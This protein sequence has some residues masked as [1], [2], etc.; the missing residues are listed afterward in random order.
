MEME[1]IIHA[2]LKVLIKFISIKFHDLVI[3]QFDIYALN[4]IYCISE[5]QSTLKYQI[6]I[7]DG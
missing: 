5:W 3:T 7:S 4:L 2:S 6:A 1:N